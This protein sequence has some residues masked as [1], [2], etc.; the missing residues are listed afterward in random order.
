[1]ASVGK[2]FQFESMNH[3]GMRGM[4]VPLREADSIPEAPGSVKEKLPSSAT[5]ERD[6]FPSA[7]IFP[8]A[9]QALWAPVK[10]ASQ[11][12]SSRSGFVGAREVS[13]PGLLHPMS[14]WASFRLLWILALFKIF[15]CRR[16]VPFSPAEGE[17]VVRWM[18]GVWHSCQP[19][20]GTPSKSVSRFL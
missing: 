6:F 1:M 12:S 13:I 3:T 20:D 10:S 7:F 17:D 16:L 8:V 5:W 9:D 11:V 2:P 18:E 14:R 15:V 19:S 4:P